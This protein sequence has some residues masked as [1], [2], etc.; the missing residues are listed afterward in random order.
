MNKLKP[1]VLGGLVVGILS[2][3]P[4]VNYCCC[5]WAIGGGLLAG[6]LYK[7]RTGSYY[8]RRRC[9]R[10]CIG[11]SGGWRNLSHRSYPNRAFVGGCGNG[12]SVP[13]FGYAHA[14]VRAPDDNRGQ[15]FRCRVFNR[16]INGRWTYSGAYFRETE[17]RRGA[18]PTGRARWRSR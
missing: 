14:L 4:F 8:Y 7:G 3:I 15:P 11:R 9:R 17:R 10:R 5:L 18:T 12:T 1:A 2:A 16:S 13:K 6:M